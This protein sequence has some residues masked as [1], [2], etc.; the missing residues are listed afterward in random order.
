MNRALTHLVATLPLVT[1]LAG[2]ADVAAP[3][4]PAT[5]LAVAAAEPAPLARS[6]YSKDASGSLSENDLQRVLET[7]VDLQFPARLGVVPL[8]APFDAQAHAALHVRAAASRDLASALV[9]D[10]HFSHV[11]DISTDLP[12]GGG[13][14]GLRVI[15]ARYRMRYLLLYSERFED[16]THVNGLGWLYPTLLG[17]FVVPG[18]TVE[19]R[20]LVQADLLDVRSGTVLFSVVEPMHVAS[21]ELM[22]GAARA[23]RELQI[24]AAAEAAKRLAGR[25]MAQT[26]QIVAYADEMATPGAR[27]RHP[28]RL[29]PAPVLADR[30]P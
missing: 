26:N 16:T 10:P 20:G 13:I 18:V 14:E 30:R 27:D 11:S 3:R 19:S 12:N 6:F 2:C 7:P 17:M 4:A 5:A 21:K 28:Q 22:I 15:A 25:V 9:G 1:L 29:L 8:A 23:H 24:K